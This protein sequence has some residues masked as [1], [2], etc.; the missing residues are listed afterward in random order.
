M[1][2]MSS[3]EDSKGAD[4][5][6]L[7]EPPDPGLDSYTGPIIEPTPQAHTIVSQTQGDVSHP[8]SSAEAEHGKSETDVQIPVEA[9]ATMSQESDIS[10]LASDSAP[11][12]QKQIE[13]HGVRQ[14]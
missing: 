6:K 5:Y 11:V 12:E 7:P 1:F 14:N 4:P 10:S 2:A 8:T 13:G 9:H 3:L